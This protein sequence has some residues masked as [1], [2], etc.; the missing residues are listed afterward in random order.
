M[1][2]IL[3]LLFVI[4][5]LT[6]SS[7]GF[8]EP[9]FNYGEALQ[10][11]IIF[12]EFQRSGKLPADK[13]DNWRGDSG[14]NDGKDQNVDLTGGWYDAGD[15]VKFNLPMSYTISMLAWSLYED[16]E[17]YV[18]SGQ[19]RYM[20]DTIKWG[21]DYLIKCHPA[22]NVYYYQV[23]EGT[24]DHAW[25]G[26]VE[27]MQMQRPSYRLDSGSPGSTVVAESAAAMAIASMV[28]QETN[29]T[30]AATCLRH[31]REMFTFA[32]TT[33]SDAGYTAANNFY[34]S[35]SGFYDELS[36]AGAWLY[37]ATK[38][39]AYLDKAESYVGFWS[40]EPNSTITAYKW[41]HCW[42]D[43]HY[44]AELLLARI[45]N[46]ALYK[47]LTEKH[48]D[49]WTTGYNGERIR[50]SPK[51]LAWLD[52]WGSLRYATTTAFL[53]S[54]YADSAV[55]TPTK[56]Q[57]YRDFAKKQVDYALGS[58]GRS[59]VVG[60]G[61]NPPKRPHHRTA[62]SS[63][64]NDQG[65]PAYHRHT[66]YGALVGG[67]DSGDGYKDDINDYVC[68][69]VA[70]DYNAGFVGILAKMYKQHGGNPIANFKAIETIEDEFFVEAAI[71]SNSTNFIEIKA[72]MN[73]RSGWPARLSTK[74]SF[75][76]FVDLT[77]AI[78]AGFR[79]SDIHT[80]FSHNEGAV[81]SNL[82]PWNEGRNIYYV[83][84]DFTGTKIYP[85]GPMDFKKEVQFR[86]SAPQNTSFW[87]NN[88]DFSFQEIKN[89][90]SGGAIK[91]QR[92]PVYEDGVKIYGQE[93]VLVLPP[94]VNLTTPQEAALFEYPNATH[95]VTINALASSSVGIAKVEF[96][97][98]NQKIGT[99][100]QAPYQLDWVPTGFSSSATGIENFVIKAKAFDAEGIST[101][102]SG[103]NIKVK[104]P[105]RVP[106]TV[107]LNTPKDGDSFDAPTA[108]RPVIFSA[109]ATAGEGTITKVRFY[110][111]D[112]L[113]G[114]DT[115]APY[116]LA[117]VPSD[118]S[119]NPGDVVNFKVAAEAVASNEATKL[120]EAALIKVKLA[121]VY[122][123]KVQMIN[124]STTAINSSISPGF[125]VLNNGRSTIDLAK[126]K[127]KYY[128]TIDGEKAQSICFDQA[129]I[130]APGTHQ[131]IGGALSGSFV[132]LTP[133]KAGAEYCL[134]ISFSSAAGKLA[135]GQ[136]LELQCRFSKNDWTNY[137]QADD[138]SFNATSA[139][140]WQKVTIQL[141][142][143][144]IWGVEP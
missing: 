33:K 92:L 12:Y 10:K 125:K 124:N 119:G 45:T 127:I 132:K 108:Q 38:E 101:L 46:K 57:G 141:G 71:S 74:L 9:A 54:V 82:M 11:S 68:N 93:P 79:P 35:W 104:L 89:T 66:L 121:E 25:W 107:E 88:N 52:Q 105:Y 83:M 1:K 99:D 22:P 48:L 131:G 7:V 137:N 28:F 96:Y 44:G 80:S 41:G 111:N 130:T 78:Q 114:E 138:Y 14:M 98:N 37:T 5:V 76:Y 69:E 56:V 43:V 18:K 2:K 26:P 61:T 53:A 100:T 91:V 70:C 6:V 36:W 117:W 110:V 129:A 97:A 17:A 3:V 67:P 94:Q 8:A 30:Y 126:T 144:L 143:T 20:L 81:I 112:Q 4:L 85:G 65:T 139:A 15:H 103:V 115:S 86:L 63:W 34:R 95:P 16:R 140:D 27:V 21:T 72:V 122:T 128:Y 60:Y 73:N 58:T 42:D 87:N 123:V 29:P 133:A 136:T 51:G 13:R 64:K 47:E 90:T 142:D 55:C 102:S 50:Y 24:L 19:L 84:V 120:S 39:Q 77:E 134:E 40:K 116:T 113:V 32:D 75:R 62:H 118:A 59:F 31:A 135:P 23:G 106:P 49:Y 109:D